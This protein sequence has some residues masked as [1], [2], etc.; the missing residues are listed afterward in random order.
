MRREGVGAQARQGG[1]EDEFFLPSVHLPFLASLQGLHTMISYPGS[2][3]LPSYCSSFH[4]C[5]MTTQEESIATNK[6]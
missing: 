2:L 1:Q 3:L 5:H 6:L 4:L